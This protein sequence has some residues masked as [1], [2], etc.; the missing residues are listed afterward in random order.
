ML[1]TGTENR[2][3][4]YLCP[5]VVGLRVRQA[6]V[7][8]SAASLVALAQIHAQQGLGQGNNQNANNNNNNPNGADFKSLEDLIQN[9]V[10]TKTWNQNGG[11][12]TI[13]DFATGVWVDPNGVLRPLMREARTV[14]LA[15][16]R[17]NNQQRSGH[18]DVHAS[19]PLRMVSL[20]RLEKA[21]QLNA[22][23]GQRADEAMRYLAGLR[24][25]QYIFAYPDTGD[26]VIAGPAGD[27]TRG[28]ENR[29]VS[30]DTGD[31]VVRLDDLVVVFRHMMKGSDAYFGCKIDPR[32]D[33]LKRAE[34][35]AAKWRGQRLPPGDTVRKE[36]CRQ[37]AAA[38]G[39]QDIEVFG[40]LDPE[41]R[42]ARTLVEADYRM[43][44][45]GLGLEPGV[46]GLASYMGLIKTPP[47]SVEM[48]RW[49]FTLN[50]DSVQTSQ[51]H[52]AFNIRGQGVKVQS[53]NEHLTALGER[54][55]TG[56][57]EP[58]NQK[59]V[60]SFTKHFDE[61]CV[62]Y[63]IYAELRNIC[64]LALAASLIREEGLTDKAGWHMTYFS[65]PRAFGVDKFRIPKEVDSV[66]N[67]RV[68]NNGVFV[69]QVSGGVAVKPSELVGPKAI[70]VE[71]SRQLQNQRP[72][73]AARRGTADRWWWD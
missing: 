68:L 9:T 63:P 65:D 7:V 55:H 57:S 54:V 11:S 16:I 23:Q 33:G 42:V 49:W 39:K 40:G 12:G 44:L 50:Y 14:K 69:V 13:S 51:D 66:V 60:E 67:Y 53:E 32:Q 62:K 3:G 37:L 34:E 10:E 21:V 64:D 73:S 2:Q 17:D 18:D 27:W 47:K 1:R 28:P 29:I 19:S 26:L 5:V 71:S 56:E 25:I 45:V 24:R 70:Q 30:S 43:K 4:G 31:P 22:T 6:F 46:P 38:L 52:L 36:Y 41:T 72:Q 15:A 61:L 59:F 8:F 58:L 20:N 48:L 35:F